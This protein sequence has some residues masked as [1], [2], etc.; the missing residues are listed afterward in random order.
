MQFDIIFPGK[1]RTRYLTEGIADFLKRLQ[2][3][4]DTTLRVTKD[5]GGS[6]GMGDDEIKIREGK[7]LLAAVEGVSVVV[8]LDAGGRMV[9]SEALAGLLQQWEIESRRNIAWI[10][11]GHVG[12]DA[13]VLARAD[14]V[15]SLSPMTFP[16][17]MVRLMLLEQ[18]YRACSIRAGR[19]YHK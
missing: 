6:G 4:S 15:L 13:S 3:F 10:I 5:W 7:A 11:G 1:T 8:A 12:L 16:H 9:S 14:L 19:K 2:P 17:E 18:L